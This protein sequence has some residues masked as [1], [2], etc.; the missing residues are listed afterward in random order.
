[1]KKRNDY[2][3]LLVFISLLCRS[4]E[5][6]MFE[7]SSKTEANKHKVTYADIPWQSSDISRAISAQSSKN[8][9]LS[10]KEWPRNGD[11]TDESFKNELKTV[12]NFCVGIRFCF[13]MGL[14]HV[15]NVFDIVSSDRDRENFFPEQSLFNIIQEKMQTSVQYI[16]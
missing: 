5:K 15:L 8:V 3:C 6:K 13:L 11:N 12:L 2:A 9:F 4:Y 7:R 1:M 14:Y 16:Y 10:S